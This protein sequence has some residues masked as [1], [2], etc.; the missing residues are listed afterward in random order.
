MIIWIA[1]SLA[2]AMFVVSI[3]SSLWRRDGLLKLGER[4]R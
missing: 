2:A 1:A 3:N 4:S